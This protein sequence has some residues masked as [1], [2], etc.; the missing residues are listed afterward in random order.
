MSEILPAILARWTGTVVLL[1]Y[2]ALLGCA[3]PSHHPGAAEPPIRTDKRVYSIN[4]G[5]LAGEQLKIVATYTNRTGGTVYPE[6]CGYDPPRFRLEKWVNGAWV[7]GY[8]QVCTLPRLDVSE[9]A[10]FS[11]PRG[12]VYMDTLSIITNPFFRRAVFHV[13]SIPGTYRIVYRLLVRRSFHGRDST[14]YV[15]PEQ[16]ISNEFKIV[17]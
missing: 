12:G 9:E 16:S 8:S 1:F 3:P 7:L 14:D 2:L 5:P 17:P 13:D 15:P 11:V 10:P 4:E 6:V